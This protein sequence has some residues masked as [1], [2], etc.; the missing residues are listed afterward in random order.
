MRFRLL[1]ILAAVALAATAITIGAANYLARN[2]KP[3]PL[4]V[5]LL[6]TGDDGLTNRFRDALEHALRTDPRFEMARAGAAYDLQMR[7]PTNLQPIAVGDHS[8]IQVLVTFADHSGKQF[9]SSDRSCVEEEMAS[10][11]EG[12]LADARQLLAARLTKLGAGRD[13]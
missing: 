12:V 9:G 5:A 2:Q 4:A 13:G 8:G 11:A 6:I 10:C 7:I 1:K 3:Q